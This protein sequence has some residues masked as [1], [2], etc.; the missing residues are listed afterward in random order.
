MKGLVHYIAAS[1]ITAS[2]F[3]GYDAKAAPLTFPSCDINQVQTWY[4]KLVAQSATNGFSVSKNWVM[5]KN[6]NEVLFRQADSVTIAGDYYDFAGPG[7]YVS[8]L[9]IPDDT[10]YGY[11]PSSTSYSFQ[12]QDNENTRCYAV[13]NGVQYTSWT[14]DSKFV[15][16]PPVIEEPTPNPDSVPITAADL[17]LF[18]MKYIVPFYKIIG[19][20]AAFLTLYAAY[21]FALKP[22][23]RRFGR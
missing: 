9:W 11:E 20:T 14:Y 23:V 21:T 19:A 22:W 1:V 13:S 7:A 18:A 12:P 2:L 6:Q 3:L 15:T 10:T 5:Y 16:Y 8:G 4:D 17:E